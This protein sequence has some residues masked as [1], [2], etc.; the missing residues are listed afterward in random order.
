[1]SVIHC[2][3]FIRF[4]NLISCSNTLHDKYSKF[5]IRSQVITNGTDIEN[6]V[7]QAILMKTKRFFVI[8]V[9]GE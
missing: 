7:F 1:M 6:I 9:V 4:K 8:A 5:G 3:T 2:L